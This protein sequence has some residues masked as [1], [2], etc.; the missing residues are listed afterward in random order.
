MTF[1]KENYDRLTKRVVEQCTEFMN[2]VV[3]KQK[4]KYKSEYDVTIDF[5]LYKTALLEQESLKLKQE[6]ANLKTK[7]AKFK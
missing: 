5:L 7:E 2:S 1:D 6:I 3:I 4:D